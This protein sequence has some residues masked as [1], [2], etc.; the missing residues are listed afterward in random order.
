MLMA[1]VC[2]PLSVF[3]STFLWSRMNVSDRA[4]FGEPP[5][6]GVQLRHWRRRMSENA[7]QPATRLRLEP[8]RSAFTAA[9]A[10]RRA[11]RSIFGLSQPTAFDRVHRFQT[12]RWRA[13]ASPKFQR[14][15]G[16]AY[17]SQASSE[18]L[19]GTAPSSYSSTRI[20][21][22]LYILFHQMVAVAQKNEA[23]KQ[24]KKQTKRISKLCIHVLL[25]GS[26]ARSAKRRLFNL[27][28]GRFWGF[29]PHRG[30]TLHRWG[31]NLA[32]RRGPKVPSFVP[33]FTPIGATI[34]V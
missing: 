13:A 16:G 2:A 30:D 7:L 26:I 32:R 12:R 17:R 6:P 24:I 3:F 9:L 23:N 27:L 14:L 22:F 33:N 15:R 31:W 5:Q 11:V 34:R 29:S 21:R 10:R 18:K 20:N 4:G 25:T 19:P 28:R 1:E 8:R